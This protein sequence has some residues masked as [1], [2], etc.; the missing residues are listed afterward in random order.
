[1]P[2]KLT[3]WMRRWR[4]T[5]PKWI[6]LSSSSQWLHGTTSQSRRRLWLTPR[7]S[8]SS[9]RPRANP[10]RSLSRKWLLRPRPRVRRT[11]I[12][13][14]PIRSSHP[15]LWVACSSQ[16]ASW[17]RRGVQGR[18]SCQPS[19]RC[20]S[21]HWHPKK[22]WRIIQAYWMTTRSRRSWTTTRRSTIWVRI[23]RA[24]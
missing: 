15:R 7:H 18:R 2:A 23:A 20:L 12:R 3:Y 19:Q 5:S 8:R 13:A 16:R 1:M 9:I 24:K 6:T 4:V 21:S 11:C 10:L 22:L 17:Q 14:I